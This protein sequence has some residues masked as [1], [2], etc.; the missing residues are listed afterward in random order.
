MLIEGDSLS[1]FRR[2]SPYIHPSG[3]ERVHYIVS[4]LVILRFCMSMYG[5]EIYTGQYQVLLVP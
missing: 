4:S 5:L 3:L 2:A 1:F